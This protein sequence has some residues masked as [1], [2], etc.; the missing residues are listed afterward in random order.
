VDHGIR[1]NTANLSFYSI[2]IDY[3]ISIGGGEG[4]VSAERQHEANQVRDRI[5]EGCR[6]I[7]EGAKWA[8]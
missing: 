6:Y 8:V 2:D 1:F 5:T 4:G 3:S 7:W